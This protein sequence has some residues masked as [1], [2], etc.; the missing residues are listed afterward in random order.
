M[1]F[2][3]YIFVVYDGW[4]NRVHS[5]KHIV[6]MEMMGTTNCK[7][8]SSQDSGLKGLL[9]R[10]LPPFTSTDPATRDQQIYAL[11]AFLAVGHYKFIVEYLG[12]C[13][14]LTL[15]SMEPETLKSDTS[16]QGQLLFGDTGFIFSSTSSDPAIENAQCHASWVTVHDDAESSR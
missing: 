2:I 7:I 3:I 12:G 4:G 14:G 16:K 5:P 11:L 8:A 9:E 10:M 1:S 15:I 13:P 6:V